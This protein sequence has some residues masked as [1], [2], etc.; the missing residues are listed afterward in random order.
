MLTLLLATNQENALT[1]DGALISIRILLEK[2]RL[3]N[4]KKN[5]LTMNKPKDDD[6]QNSHI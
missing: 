5:N 4:V 1:F 6:D 2:K 3:G